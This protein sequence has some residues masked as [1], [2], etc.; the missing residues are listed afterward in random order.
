MKLK[1]LFDCDDTLYD[2]SEPFK[3]S[4]KQLIPYDQRKAID[5]E[6]FYMDYRK[7]G[8]GI[9][10]RIQSGEISVDEAGMY[11]IQKACE[12]YG[13]DMS[14]K[15]AG[16]FQ[17]TYR[18]YQKEIHMSSEL[19]TYLAHTNFE[20]GVLTN[21]EDSHQ[22]AK[23]QALGIFDYIPETHVFTSGQ[24]GYAKPDPRAFEYALKHLDGPA[25]SWYYVGDHYINDIE[26]AK[27]VGMQTIHFNRHHQQEGSASDYIVYSEKELIELLKELSSQ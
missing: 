6:Q 18:N 11:R 20:L 13:I 12:K 1:L 19:K 24:I 21:G 4:V 2:L 9:F 22:L 14:D 10:D 3:R 25:E 27:A 8:D 16:N 7:A 15:E 17:R 26:G 23:C 5:L